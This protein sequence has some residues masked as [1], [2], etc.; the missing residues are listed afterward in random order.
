MQVEM[1]HGPKITDAHRKPF[2]GERRRE[3][4]VLVW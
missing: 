4:E 2:E 3:V 1:L